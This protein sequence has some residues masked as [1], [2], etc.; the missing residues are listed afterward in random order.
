MSK[1]KCICFSEVVHTAGLQFAIK[2][3]SLLI[4]TMRGVNAASFLPQCPELL[5][6]V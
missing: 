2:K 3:I 5:L 1:L 6:L 4:Q